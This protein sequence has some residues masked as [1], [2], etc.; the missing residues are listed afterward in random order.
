MEPHR[1]AKRS[2]PTYT[3][4]TVSSFCC[5][6]LLNQVASKF[7]IAVFHS[8]VSDVASLKNGGG[9]SIEMLEKVDGNFLRK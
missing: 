2:L 9:F 1:C 5:A 3:S 8:F 7:F 6:L 4:W